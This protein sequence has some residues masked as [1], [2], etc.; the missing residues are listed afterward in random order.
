MA[1]PWDTFK[2]MVYHIVNNIT[3]TVTNHTTTMSRAQPNTCKHGAPTSPLYDILQILS[4]KAAAVSKAG[5]HC[6]S[7]HDRPRAAHSSM[8]QNLMRAQNPNPVISHASSQNCRSTTPPNPRSIPAQSELS[9]S[10]RLMR[11]MQV[12]ASR[13][14][15]QWVTSGSGLQWNSMQHN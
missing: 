4:S 6:L 14:L 3:M 13:P 12:S 5:T 15:L 11:C 7:V 8:N 10:Y 9:A 1:I 2:V